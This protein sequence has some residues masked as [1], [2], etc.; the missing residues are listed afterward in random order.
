MNQL[1][2]YSGR[3]YDVHFKA[4]ADLVASVSGDGATIAAAWRHDT[5]E[6]TPATFEDIERQSGADV[7]GSARELTDLSKPADGNRTARKAIDRRHLAPASPRAKTITLA[8]I[9]DTCEDICRHDAEFARVC[10]AEMSSGTSASP[11][12]KPTTSRSVPR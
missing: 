8:D 11:R 2:K 4:V 5:V 9:V 6:D 3:P 7:A 10:L 12:R 1:R